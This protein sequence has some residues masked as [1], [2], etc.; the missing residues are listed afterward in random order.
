MNTI[1]LGNLVLIIA[2][3]QGN[4]YANTSYELLDIS[5]GYKNKTKV[6]AIATP[7]NHVAGK[8]NYYTLF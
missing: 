5:S 3:S 8:G 2:H 1:K 4:F 6:V 7:A